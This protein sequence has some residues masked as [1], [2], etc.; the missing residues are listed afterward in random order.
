MSAIKIEWAGNGIV[1]HGDILEG[2]RKI[3]FVAHVGPEDR[4]VLDDALA[5]REKCEAL[6]TEWRTASHSADDGDWLADLHASELEALLNPKGE[7]K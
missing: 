7:G 1:F 4:A 3:G 2:D 6:I 5:L